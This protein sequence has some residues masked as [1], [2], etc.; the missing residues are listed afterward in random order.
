MGGTKRP[1]EAVR[2][3]IIS[4][5]RAISST[6]VSINISST[7]TRAITIISFRFL[8][9]TDDTKRALAV[10]AA[11]AAVDLALDPALAA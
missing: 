4:T 11:S 1:L 5:N 3:V 6:R 9:W 10:T 2:K 8:L 7:I